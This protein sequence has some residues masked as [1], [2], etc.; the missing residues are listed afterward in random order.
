[1]GLF[2]LAGATVMLCLGQTIAILIVGRLLQGIAAAVVWVAG[3]SLLVDT[4]GQEDIGRA[5]GTVSLAMN[6]PLL[7]GPVLGG[8]VYAERGYFP[9]YYMAFGLVFLDILLRVALVEKKVASKWMEELAESGAR[10][11]Q[12]HEE[13]AIGDGGDSVHPASIPAQV[14]PPSGTEGKKGLKSSTRS[15]LPP[16]LTLLTSRRLL[17]AVWATAVQGIFLSALDTTV[18]L[19]VKNIFGWSSLGAGLVFIGLVLPTFLAPLV[20]WLSDKHGPRWFSVAGFLL[21]AP[22]FALFRF[23]DHGG[24]DQIVLMCALMLL[25]GITLTLMVTPIMAEFLYV[26]E[27]KERKTPG[28]YGKNGAY[29]QA[30]ALL[31]T[32]FAIGNMAGPIW[33]GFVVSAAGWKTMSWSLALLSFVSTIPVFIWSGGFIA[34]RADRSDQ[35]WEKEKEGGQAVTTDGEV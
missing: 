6:L 12:N 25:L 21:T 20:G 13:G 18:P 2:A 9:V 22:V 7:L 14:E 1:M 17:T 27:A 26:V 28:I 8:I 16:V 30:Y 19:H 31:I 4:V 34:R 11:I 24:I 10:G 29:A 23:V 32:S 33:S 35:C 3:L 5:I 15:Q